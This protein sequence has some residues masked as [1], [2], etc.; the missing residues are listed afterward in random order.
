MKIN[1][2]KKEY[3]LLLDIVYLG[4]W[5]ME[6]HQ[7]GEP[8]E[9][10]GYEMLVQ[11]IYSFAKDMGCED[12]VVPEKKMNKFY[13]SRL[14]EDESGVHEIIDRYNDDSFWDELVNRLA[15]RDARADAKALNREITSAQ[16]FWELSAPHESRYAD[17][18]LENGL[19]NLVIG[20]K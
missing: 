7:V 19:G 16:E 5:M 14:Y 17:E 2:T 15:E 3:R 10:D 13:T 11:K 9:D 12:L 1:F 20:E 4:Q 18:F 6:A 8:D